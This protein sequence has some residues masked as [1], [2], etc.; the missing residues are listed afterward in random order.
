MEVV[1]MESKGRD[2]GEYIDDLK[3]RV[4]SYL[5]VPPYIIGIEADSMFPLTIMKLVSS[6]NDCHK[7]P[8]PENGNYVT[9]SECWDCIRSA[10]CDI[11]ATMLDEDFD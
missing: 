11:Y 2:I 4:A 5:A 7:F 9:L 6:C 3:M 1:Y 10:N 8:C